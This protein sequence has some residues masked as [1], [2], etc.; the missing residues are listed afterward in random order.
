MKPVIVVAAF[1][2]GDTQV[3]AR[4]IDSLIQD[5]R[6][7]FPA[8][9]VC[10]AWTSAFLRK[11]LA[12]AGIIYLSLEEQLQQLLEAGC[13]DVVILPTVLTPGEEYQNKILPMAEQFQGRFASLKVCEP[14]LT[15]EG[16]EGFAAT[17]AAILQLEELAPEEELVLMGHGSP[18]H[19]NPVYEW[20]Q[21][22]VAEQLLP[23]HIGVVEKEDYPN[24]ADVQQRLQQRGVSKVLLR[25]MLLAG[26]NHATEDLA[27]D[28]P[29]SWKSVLSQQGIQ[30]RCSLKGLGEYEDFRKLFIEKL[31]IVA[32]ME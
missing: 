10:E 8:Y 3:K 24:Q 26:G 7:A 21:A 19:H 11:K 5:I 18:H 2:V 30:V 25:P 4:C 28:K 13:E 31:R 15:M 12:R 22:Y 16:P 14:L 23:V 20:F 9:D 1:G 32:K 29:D 6:A 27:G 17:A